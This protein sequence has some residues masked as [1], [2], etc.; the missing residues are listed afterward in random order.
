[1]LSLVGAFLQAPTTRSPSDLV[2]GTELRPTYATADAAIPSSYPHPSKN[3]SASH[4]APGQIIECS[5]HSLSNPQ[6]TVPVIP[7]P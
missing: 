2:S 4:V 6:P 3:V 7:A 1:M 5:T